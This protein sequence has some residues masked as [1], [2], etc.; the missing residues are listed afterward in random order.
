M[1]DRLA[2]FSFLAC[3]FAPYLCG[4]AMLVG[5]LL[6]GLLGVLRSLFKEWG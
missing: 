4:T 1:D 5:V 3:E 2:L 6:A